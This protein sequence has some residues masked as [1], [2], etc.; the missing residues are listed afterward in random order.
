MVVL[1]DQAALEGHLHSR[2]CDK[3]NP[4]RNLRSR[5]VWSVPQDC[6]GSAMTTEQ[7]TLLPTNVDDLAFQHSSPHSLREHPLSSPPAPP[8]NHHQQLHDEV[9]APLGDTYDPVSET[10]EGQLSEA[11]ATQL[12]LEEDD[13]RI[14]GVSS[15]STFPASAFDPG[16]T[17][18]ATPTRRNGN[19]NG[20]AELPNSVRRRGGYSSAFRN[21]S[22]VVAM[23]MKDEIYEDAVNL[24]PQRRSG[25][26][27]SNRS[28]GSNHSAYTSPSKRVS[29]SSQSSPLKG[30]KLKKEF[31]LVL[32]HCT[33][34]TPAS[35]LL[36]SS[37]DAELFSAI[38]PD[39]YRKRWN[40]LHDRLSNAEVKARGVLIPH[41][42]E[43]YELLEERLLECLDLEN[44][45][46][47]NNHF[48]DNEAN[49]ADSGFEDASQTED[50]TEDSVK[51]P[52]CGKCLVEKGK[53]ERKWEVKVYAANGLMR[54]GAWSAAWREM[55]KVDVEVGIWMPE[56]VRREV[57][58]RL[59]AIKAS[60]QDVDDHRED[61]HLQ[62]RRREVYGDERQRETTRAVNKVFQDSEADYQRHPGT[63]IHGRSDRADQDNPVT[64]VRAFIGDGK[65]V[66]ILLLS[67]LVLSYA[68]IHGKPSTAGVINPP[69]STNVA[70]VSILTVTSAALLTTTTPTTEPPVPTAVDA[71]AGSETLG[72]APHATDMVERKQLET[73]EASVPIE[74]SPENVSIFTEGAL[75]EADF[76]EHSGARPDQDARQD[77]EGVL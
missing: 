22:S 70:D 29:R 62:D 36:F 26:R 5:Y 58:E 37:C 4:L 73:G 34:L 8:L 39:E 65:N 13:R 28:H 55:E 10:D 51:C 46:I 35:N 24:T 25:S 23:Q 60:E 64:G 17:S 40:K 69:S 41:P 71:S 33:L 3:V 19:S 7:T 31:P 66:M 14:S 68:L 74:I 16:F 61:E 18:P 21:P 42:Q 49:A 72:Q 48:F 67:V 57:S 59:E 9:F 56:D 1:H 54:A 63:T 15:V 30:S 32:L 44:P 50:E 20:V 38:L 52:D 45:R 53:T 77:A 75:V 12:S 43:D 6:N 76:I 27:I 2:I 47:R 11:D